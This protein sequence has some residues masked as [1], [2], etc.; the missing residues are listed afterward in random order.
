MSEGTSVLHSFNCLP[1]NFLK[2]VTQSCAA[3]VLCYLKLL[4]DHGQVDG[5]QNAFSHLYSVCHGEIGTEDARC[6]KIR[7]LFSKYN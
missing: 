1:V 3:K 2:A 4:F 5:S 7:K 6:S